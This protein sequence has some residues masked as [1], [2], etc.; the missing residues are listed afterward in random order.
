MKT[1]LF[2]NAVAL[3]THRRDFDSGERQVGGPTRVSRALAIVHAAIYNAQEST[4][5]HAGGPRYYL[6]ALVPPAMTPMGPA[7]AAGAVAGAA[8]AVL[9]RLWPRQADR[10]DDKMQ[11]FCDAEV[12]A[13]ANGRA[14]MD[15]ANYGELI[16]LAMYTHRL[17][18][19]NERPDENVF[20]Y[21]PGH[22]QPDPAQ[23]A[24]KRLST[25]WGLLKPFLI[26][27]GAGGYA[28]HA[29][30]FADPPAMGT[31][32]DL[33][34]VADVQLLG[35]ASS[36]Y[37]QPGER[38]PEQTTVGIFWGYD[39]PPPL[40]VPPRLYNQLVRAFVDEQAK[41]A[42]GTL[43]DAEAAHLF[44]LVNFAMA[45]AAIVAWG[46]KYHHDLWRPVVGIR[47]GAPGLGPASGVL[48]GAMPATADPA[49]LPLGI[50]R[51]GQTGGLH[52]TPD[53][54]AY[55]SGH[56]TFGAAA[57]RV[58]ALF[59]AAKLGVPV[60]DVLRH[61]EFA[62]MSDEYDGEQRG[63]DGALRPRLNKRLTLAKAIIDNA[64]SRVYLG[65][66]WRFD[67]L[68]A[69][70][71]DGL[72]GEPLPADPAGPVQLSDAHEKRLGGVAGGL[73]VAE[74]VTAA[75]P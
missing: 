52:Y 27:V 67:G 40:G 6:P 56:A 71:P 45:D 23:A 57:C 62:F 30:Y 63:D 16:G 12:A 39:G 22:H 60:G 68:G 11:E 46:A 7:N 42:A 38:S 65:V 8:V 54:P 47:Q 72:E 10:I 70:A 61:R 58:T 50:P 43:S 49:W 25:H 3:E 14:L 20:V 4:N 33:A 32:R 59:Y 44:A 48:A 13:G 73:L 15:G 24:Q 29:L 19:G 75:L 36:R 53:F 5:P 64:V 21:Q 2:W 37:P 34:A 66:H 1:I 55:P 41:N 28:N 26:P 74:Q 18:D 51:T 17:A 69:V 35:R 9:K 31:P